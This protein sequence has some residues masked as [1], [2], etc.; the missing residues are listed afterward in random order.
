VQHLQERRCERRLEPS[1]QDS[2]HAQPPAAFRD[3][4]VSELSGGLKKARGAGRAPS[5]WRPICSSST[6]R[7]TISISP[8]IEW[9]EE[10]L[11]GFAGSVLFRHAR[12]ALPRLGRAADRRA[13]PRTLERAYPGNYRAYQQK[14]VEELETEAVH[15]R[16]FDKVLA[17]EEVWIRKGI[18]ARRNEER[19]PGAR[20]EAL[21]TSARRGATASARSAWSSPKAS[22][23]AA[24]SR[25]WKKS[26]K[27]YGDKRVVKKFTGRILRGDKVG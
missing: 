13:R 26:E 14:K 9:L 6:S 21:R 11:L 12:P 16:K 25:T 19:R 22:A 3:D 17:Q 5:S 10:T 2:G 24:W 4:P 1:A 15:Q 18:E 23:R 7:P 20:L 8:A 27:N